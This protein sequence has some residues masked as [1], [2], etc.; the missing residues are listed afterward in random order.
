VEEDEIGARCNPI[1][2]ARARGR[3]RSPWMR[4]ADLAVDASHEDMAVMVEVG[5]GARDGTDY[6][7]VCSQVKKMGE[8]EQKRI[9]HVPEILGYMFLPS[10]VSYHKTSCSVLDTISRRSASDAL[11]QIEL[12]IVALIQTLEMAS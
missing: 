4:L 3:P 2:R 5:R 9:V 7:G 8:G 1:E 10:T 6:Q 12:D 11:N